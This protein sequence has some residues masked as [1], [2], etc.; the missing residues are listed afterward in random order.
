[1]PEWKQPM[2]K[3]I[4]GFAIAV[5]SLCCANEKQSKDAGPGQRDDACRVTAYHVTQTNYTKGTYR[6]MK[7]ELFN[8][9]IVV[10]R[11]STNDLPPKILYST[12]L[13]PEQK[14]K[15]RAIICG[16]DLKKMKNEYINKN[17]EGEG[18]SVYDIQINQD[19]KSIYVYF[20]EEPSIK[21]LDE[22][23]NE[24]LPKNQNGWYEAY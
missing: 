1:M 3:Y 8:D 5:L 22:F 9:T 2:K 10:T 4:A 15:L 13:N 17:V 14:L 6:T 19:S 24:I 7:F 12:S 18:H 21:K 16:I 11:Y 23:I 20:A